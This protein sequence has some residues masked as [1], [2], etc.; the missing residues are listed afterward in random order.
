MEFVC[1]HNGAAVAS[2][3]SPKERQVLFWAACVPARISLLAILL[4]LVW[5]FPRVMAGAAVAAGCAACA[6]NVYLSVR[7]GCR[8]WTP[9]TSA[10]LAFVAALCGALYLAFPAHISPFLPACLLA[11]HI[12]SGSM[13]ALRE[14]PWSVGQ[15]K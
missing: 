10:L 4:T 12:L 3:R 14:K 9:S 1:K 2:R 6:F 8:W 11:A 7:R 13:Q 5:F 15:E